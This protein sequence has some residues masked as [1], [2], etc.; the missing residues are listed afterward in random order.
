MSQDQNNVVNIVRPAHPFDI[1]TP[2]DLSS[3]NGKTILITGG[4]SGF[5]EGFFRKWA[6]NGMLKS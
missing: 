3:L 2:L 1:E 5:G 4:A 6:E